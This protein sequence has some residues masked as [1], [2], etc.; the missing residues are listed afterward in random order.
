VSA[1]E[2]L[3]KA[4]LGD[5]VRTHVAAS[6]RPHI[7]VVDSP[8]APR[9]KLSK[10]S[11]VFFIVEKLPIYAG[12]CGTMVRGGIRDVKQAGMILLVRSSSGLSL[13]VE[14]RGLGRQLAVVRVSTGAIATDLEKAIQ[15]TSKR[16]TR[17]S[18]GA[19]LRVFRIAGMHV[20]AVWAHRPK[21]RGTDVFVP[22]TL[23]FA[24]LRLGRTY[25]LHR[26]ESLMKKHA[27]NMI[28]RWYDRYEKSVTQPKS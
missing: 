13:H 11:N 5:Y 25:K 22:Y 7:R 12:S 27:T 17:R 15:S 9:R 14:L 4:Q 6:E 16:H 18:T 26:I 1:L 19:E 3:L 2:K 20:S 23:N 28:L 21:K 24:G 10:E 8:H